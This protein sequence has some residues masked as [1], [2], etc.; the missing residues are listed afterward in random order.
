MM[1]DEV[2]PLAGPGSSVGVAKV[3]L[4]KFESSAWGRDRARNP[5]WAAAAIEQ[6]GDVLTVPGFVVIEA[7]DGFTAVKEGLGDP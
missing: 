5:T 6:M 7:A 2:D 1:E 4:D 3:A